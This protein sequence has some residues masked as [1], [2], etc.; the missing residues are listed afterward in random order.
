MV[1]VQYYIASSWNN[2][3]VV[4]DI[5]DAQLNEEKIQ[6]HFFLDLEQLATILLISC[7]LE[8]SSGPCGKRL[9]V[10]LMQ[11][12]S[13]MSQGK[14]HAETVPGERGYPVTRE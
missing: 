6:I 8:D 2:V 1:I 9:I 5:W 3:W 7:M 4:S 13:S 14:K 10:V 11:P 12:K